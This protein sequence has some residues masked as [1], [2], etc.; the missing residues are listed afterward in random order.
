D[1]KPPKKQKGSKEP[2]PKQPSEKPEK[3]P[4]KQPEKAA[5]PEIKPAKSGIIPINKLNEAMEENAQK[6]Q[7]KKQRQ[8]QSKQEQKLKQL[9]G[10]AF[11]ELDSESK[12]FLTTNIKSIQSITQRYLYELGYP[13]VAIKTRQKGDNIVEFTL[14][15]NGDISGLKLIE[16]SG[17]RA[18]DDNSREL[19]EVAYKDYPLPE[20]KTLIRIKVIYSAF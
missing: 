9:Y 1:K 4:E 8:A 6:Q 2:A 18:L 14:H 7:K 12:Q 15:P 3:Q 11:G 17:Y 16:S 10:D 5:S 19:I 13:P 20:S